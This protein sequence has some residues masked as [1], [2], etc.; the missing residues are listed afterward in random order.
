MYWK[1][2]RK[3]K[4]EFIN[5]SA[6]LFHTFIGLPLQVAPR[7]LT[8][9]YNLPMHG[10]FIIPITNLPLIVNPTE[11]VTKGFLKREGNIFLK[12]F[13][14]K[15]WWFYE[16]SFLLLA[17]FKDRSWLRSDPKISIARTTSLRSKFNWDCIVLRTLHLIDEKEIWNCGFVD[18]CSVLIL[19]LI[20]H[21][22][23]EISENNAKYFP[24]LRY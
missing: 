6:P 13:M 10:A 20:P 5:Q 23:F 12:P 16:N 1:F 7:P 3:F 22:G 17:W 9:A 21:Y 24:L 18:L 19:I 8:A 14:K 4:Y 11:I 15:S 2:E